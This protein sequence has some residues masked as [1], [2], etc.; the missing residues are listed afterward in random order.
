MII[1]NSDILWYKILEFAYDSTVINHLSQVKIYKI[2]QQAYY[3][4][5]TH[6][7]IW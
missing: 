5:E 6:D 3:W 1:S 2:V 7:F 4:S